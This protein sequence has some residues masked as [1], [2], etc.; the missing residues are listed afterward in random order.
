[1]IKTLFNTQH[2]TPGG[3]TESLCRRQTM[4][5]RLVRPCDR[6]ATPLGITLSGWTKLCLFD[7]FPFGWFLI[8]A[9]IFTALACILRINPILG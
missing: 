5:Y 9:R 3:T 1:M 4:S 2:L 6:M 8:L 7:Y